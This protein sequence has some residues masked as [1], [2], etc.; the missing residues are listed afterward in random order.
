MDTPCQDADEENASAT[1]AQEPEAALAFRLVQPE[2]VL[3]DAADVEQAV[4]SLQP[5]AAGIV[6]LDTESRARTTHPHRAPAAPRARSTRYCAF[7]PGNA[8]PT[9]DPSRTRAD[10]LRGR[11]AP[12]RRTAVA[13][14]GC[15]HRAGARRV[16][17]TGG[18]NAR[19]ERHPAR[20]ARGRERHK[21]APWHH[22]P[23]RSHTPP[24]APDQRQHLPLHT[25]Y[26]AGA[27]VVR[28]S[29]LCPAADTRRA[30]AP[31]AAR[32]ASARR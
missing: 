17:E 9:R 7:L 21:G 14:G 2:A 23:H 16:V 28:G 27:G 13:V 24:V 10:Q 22:T 25:V 18:R 19:T 6:G 1:T 15:Q 11:R 5:H 32:W 20:A 31:G 12:R 29:G 8:P 30:R 26:Y 3:Y 4:L